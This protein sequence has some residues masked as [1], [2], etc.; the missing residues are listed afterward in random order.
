MLR[1]FDY[2][3]RHATI[4]LPPSHPA[5]A[6]ADLWAR[7]ARAAFLAGYGADGGAP[8]LADGPAEAALLR[9]LEIDK[10]MYEVVYETLNRPAWVQIPLTALERLTAGDH[11]QGS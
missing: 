5:V 11:A 1:S 10:A 8:G 3:A 4:G 2:A 7:Q 6:A 9:A